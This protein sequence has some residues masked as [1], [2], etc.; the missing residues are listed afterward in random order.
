MFGISDNNQQS[1]DDPA[2]LDNIKQLATQPADQVIPPQPSSAPNT[3]LTTQQATNDNQTISKPLQ[4]AG[5]AQSQPDSNTGD[6]QDTPQEPLHGFS[7]DMPTPEQNNS[8]PEQTEPAQAT[9]Q[10]P[11]TNT[12]P[13]NEPVQNTP[14]PEL[15]SLSTPT[16]SQ[17]TDNPSNDDANADD[18]S[19]QPNDNTQTTTSLPQADPTHLAGLKQQALGHLEPL[20]EHLDGTPEET[21]KTTMMMIQANDN[22][23]LLEKALEAAQKI[24]DDKVR[25]QALL[26]II[27]E[28]NYF[29]QDQQ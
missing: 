7:M 2:M 29:S 13:A 28:I 22:H 10:M 25:A 21:F 23:T 1:N 16:A 24:E 11:E 20:T 26:D 18:D 5:P 12:E 8:E 14:A 3:P 15:G 19:S 17:P 27:N 6:A 9:E 4:Q